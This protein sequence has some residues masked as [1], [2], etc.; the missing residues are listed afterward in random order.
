MNAA[1]D[2][3][4]ARTSKNAQ[5]WDYFRFAVEAWSFEYSF[6]VSPDS[7]PDDPLG[8]CAERCDLIVSG[9]LR[10]KTRRRCDRA[11]LHVSADGTEPKNW[12]NPKVRG[13]GRVAG[14]RK[15]VLT[16]WLRI[17]P[18]SFQA[19]ATALAAGKVRGLYVHMSEVER[20]AGFITHFFTI[21][22]DEPDE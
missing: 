1:Y 18:A 8:I 5:S 7:K 14:V 19:F 9:P 20:G 17:P 21:D 10:S 6:R 15:G 11:S 12:N 22:P 13:F 2:R 3:A 16:G 4:M